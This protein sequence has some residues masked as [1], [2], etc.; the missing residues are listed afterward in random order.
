M[1]GTTPSWTNRSPTPSEFAVPRGWSNTRTG[2]AGHHVRGAGDRPVLCGPLPLV[3][4]ASKFD[5][6]RYPA[7]AT[8]YP[9]EEPQRR[10]RAAHTASTIT[11]Y[12]AYSPE[13]GLPAVREGRF[14][15]GW[16]RDRMTWIKPLSQTPARRPV[17]ARGMPVTPE[18]QPCRMSEV[19]VAEWKPATSEASTS[20]QSYDRHISG[21]V[22]LHSL[23]YVSRL[24]HVG[25][26]W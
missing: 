16:K 21:P 8:L 17:L 19:V 12:Q 9:M 6:C 4:E 18:T 1:S 2:P 26:G 23:S 7:G 20:H 5:G 24:V 22:R 14:P 13:I 3:V 15:T 11:V 25:T 10:I